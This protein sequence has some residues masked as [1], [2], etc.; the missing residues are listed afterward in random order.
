MVTLSTFPDSEL[1]SLLSEGKVAAFDT[2]YNR[3]W[4]KAL[5]LAHHKTGDLMEAE[6]VVQDVF[7]SLWKR[8]NSLQLNGPFENYL[9]VSVK[10]RVLKVLAKRAAQR[11]ESLDIAGDLIDDATQEYL[12][13]DEL[14]TRLEKLIGT[15]PE[16][17]QLVY[18]LSK[19]DGKSYKEIAAEL[20]ISEKAVD[21]HLVRAKRTLRAGLGSFLGNFLL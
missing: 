6:N 11:T 13:F 15:L 5:S 14:R 4:K 3:Y 8:R 1:L 18:R 20:D 10:Y 17:S 9:V 16:K 21:A 2:L 19:E 7:V 12:A